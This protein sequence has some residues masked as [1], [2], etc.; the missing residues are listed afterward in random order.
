MPAIYALYI[1]NK[2]GGLIYAKVLLLNFY[3][4]AIKSFER[5]DNSCSVQDFIPHT[6]V[7][8]NDT[9]RLASMW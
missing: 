4:L 9:L 7:S 3:R 5:L 1:I 6:R 2:S 8:T